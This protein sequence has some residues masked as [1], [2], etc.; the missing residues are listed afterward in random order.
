MGF[1]G[2]S[3]GWAGPPLAWKNILKARS[4]LIVAVSAISFSVTLIFMQLGLLTAI[5]KAAILLY[6]SLNFDIALVSP[7]SPEL[8]SPQP[9]P[10][11][12][13][14]QALGLEAVTNAMPIYITFREWR[15]PE[16]R[17]LR[18]ILM[19]GFNPGDEAFRLADVN[20]QLAA[21]EKPDAVLMSRLSRPEFGPRTVGLKTELN[22]RDV[23][24]AG[25][26]EVSNTIRSDGTL[27]M[28]T[29]NFIRYTGGASPADVYLGLLTVESGG[30]V[31]AVVERLREILPDDVEVLSR[32]EVNARDQRFWVQSSSMGLIVIVASTTAFVVGSVVV[33][34]IL[35]ADV[36]E[37]L[38]EYAT[39]KAMGYGNGKLARV[40]LQQSLIL[41]IL[42]FIPAC[43]LGIGIY[44][45]I[46]LA[47]R[48]PIA[49]TLG[50]AGFVLCL[51]LIMCSASGMLAL[52][53]VFDA[54]PAEIF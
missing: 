27:L 9:F 28:S 40:V 2:K 3:S 47:T 29:E 10:R 53:R 42:G 35:N 30:D 17:R 13:L 22:D 49:M 14:Y 34:Q 21:L 37:H 39:L 50:R 5:L 7:K 20:D 52:R 4:R 24:V 32:E 36:S 12:R 23:E 48:L 31:D 6:D 26:V 11:R 45:A 15:N 16:N 1:F 8:L 19:V 38:P 25:L 54:D 51:T 46:F 43:L 33:Y 18:S 41:A 44:R